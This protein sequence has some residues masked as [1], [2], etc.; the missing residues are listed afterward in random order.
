MVGLV[1]F[2]FFLGRL[3]LV[4][5]LSWCFWVLSFGATTYFSLLFS[6][7]VAYL[8]ALVAFLAPL[9]DGLGFFVGWLVI[10]F[11]LA[12]FVPSRADLYSGNFYSG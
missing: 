2:V 9:L 6:I 1:S 10:T 8:V 11:V 3:W 5:Y 7:W 12:A 4:C